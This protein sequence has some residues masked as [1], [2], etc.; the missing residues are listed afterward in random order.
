[1]ENT[2]NHMATKYRTFFIEGLDIRCRSV[3]AAW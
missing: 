3:P 1:M 2:F